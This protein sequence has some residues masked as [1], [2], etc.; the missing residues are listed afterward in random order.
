VGEFSKC[1]EE[2]EMSTIFLEG[3]FKTALR[4]VDEKVEGKC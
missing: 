4:K 3:F 1:V 2:R